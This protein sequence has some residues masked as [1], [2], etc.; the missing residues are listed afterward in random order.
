MTP[1]IGLI[2]LTTPIVVNENLTLTH[3]NLCSFSHEHP[4]PWNNRYGHFEMWLAY[5][6]LR[7]DGHMVEPSYEGLHIT[8]TESQ[9]K[10]HFDALSAVVTQALPLANDEKLTIGQFLIDNGYING[11]LITE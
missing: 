7:A 9:E 1:D 3:L 6:Y 8:I 10:A 2:E 11:T 5:G 4:R